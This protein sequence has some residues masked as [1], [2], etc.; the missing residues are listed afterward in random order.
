MMDSGRLVFDP[1]QVR[2]IDRIAIEELGIP[3]YE[4]MC[5]AGRAVCD[6][7]Q[8]RFPQAAP[9]LVLC[10]AGNNAGDGYVVA[11]L[12][13]A[14]G[15]EVAV[16]AL[17][18]PLLLQGDAARAWREF[19]A[20]G[21]QT[22]PFS[23]ALVARAG[24]VI[25]A[26]LGTGLDRELGG[27]YREAAEVLCAM[28][29]PVIAVD[30][31]TGLCARTGAILG[32]AVVADVT[33]TFIGRKLGLYVGVGPEHAGAIEFDDLGVPVAGLARV[34]PVAR[35]LDDRDCARCLP[36]RARQAHKG[37]FGHVLVVGGNHG[38]GGAVRLAGEAALRAGAGLVT[39]ATRPGNVASVVCARPELMCR[40]VEQPADLDD[41]L[42]RATVVAVGPGL[43]QDAWGRALF[44]RL[45]GVHQPLVAD[46][47]ALNLL[48]EQ[49]MY[50][51]DWVLT[52]HPGEASRLL[53]CPVTQVQAARLD[54]ARQLSGR[55]GGVAVLKGCCTLIARD[56]DVPLLI[57]AG[58]PGMATGGMGDVLTGLIAGLIAQQRGADLLLASAC[59]ALIHGRAGDA[60]ARAGERGVLAGDLLGQLRPWLNPSR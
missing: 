33:V 29:R 34:Q 36:R 30:I 52:P 8:R 32:A 2:E 38:M 7:G 12:A 22:V 58:N 39:V 3:G 50:R 4:L 45:R 17:S 9:W 43:G 54:S 53:G 1:E 37:H 26:M 55:Y 51:D 15:I 25:D 24:L 48:A 23:E 14:A 28:S 20:A 44:A 57:D 6:L 47:D 13:R 21:G 18:D 11:R 16:A 56:G 35:L 27:V 46:A 41:L 59:G 19:S 5:R 31:P 40:G 60:A 42:A 49:P 10:G